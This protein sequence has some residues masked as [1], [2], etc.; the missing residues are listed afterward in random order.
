M[1]ELKTWKGGCHRSLV[2]GESSGAQVRPSS[3]TRGFILAVK[4]LHFRKPFSPRETKMVGQLL[5]R[6]HLGN[7][8]FSD[9]SVTA[10]ENNPSFLPSP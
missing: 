1:L 10:K 4:F 6:F 2:S 7:F 9:A 5:P 8:F 3:L